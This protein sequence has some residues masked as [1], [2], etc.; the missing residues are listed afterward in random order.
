MKNYRIKL[1]L[2]AAQLDAATKKAAQALKAPADAADA[3]AKKIAAIQDRFIARDYSGRVAHERRKQELADQGAKRLQAIQDG[4]LAREYSQRVAYQAKLA[5]RQVSDAQSRAKKLQSVE[6]GYLAKEYAQ[7]VAF[8][9]R[10]EK[11]A[12]AAIARQAKLKVKALT[13]EE[14]ALK[15]SNARMS[16]ANGQRMAQA[17]KAAGVEKKGFD[18]SSAAASALTGS[19]TS[20]IGAAVGFT[21][22]SGLIDG[23]ASSFDAANQEAVRAAD[24]VRGYRDSLLELAALKG[25]LGNTDQALADELGFR[26][27][28]LQTAAQAKEFRSSAFG[29]GESN[30]ED[31]RGNGF[32]SRPEFDVAM[33]L[34]GKFQA[35]EGGDAAAHGDLAGMMPGLLGKKGLTG[36]ESFAGEKKIFDILKPGGVSFSKGVDQLLKQAA[37]APSFGDVYREAAVVSAY[38]KYSKEEAGTRTGQL[39]RAT[40]GGLGKTGVPRVEG[41]EPVGEYLKRLGASDQ[42]DVIEIAKKISLDLTQQEAGAKAAGRE[43]KPQVYLKQ[44]GYANQEDQDAIA[45]FHRINS[46]GEF[47]ASFLRP[48][49]APADAD[50][51]IREIERKQQTDPALRARKGDLSLDAGATAQGS[52][53]ME[54]YNSL[55]KVAYGRLAARASSEGTSIGGFDAYKDGVFSKLN[56]HGEMN[57]VMREAQLKAGIGEDSVQAVDYSLFGTTRGMADQF[58]TIDRDLKGRNVDPL[59]AYRGTSEVAEKMLTAADKMNAAADKQVAGR[60]AVAPR[61]AP[62]ALPPGPRAGPGR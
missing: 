2:D 38:S 54:F 60:R 59:D 43:F 33:R 44:R 26:R 12:A 24:F 40:L 1:T 30:I 11:A 45:E 55:Q 48:A 17:L 28:T 22:V 6:D 53:A 31:G 41:A 58:E 51:M 14:V 15:V 23:I 37:I 19:F 9:A 49:M 21:S 32:I 56:L 52:G 39:A 57:E 25:T 29:S 46:T 8:E 61:P 5:A 34:G 35:T 20:L 10:K 42:M 47:D 62:A 7:R 16:L 3:S 50:G 13:D 27:D 18:M 4:Y 36:K